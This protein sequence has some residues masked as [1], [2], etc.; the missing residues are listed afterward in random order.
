MHARPDSRQ[1]PCTSE[2]ASCVWRFV[3][4]L[5]AFAWMPWINN[6]HAVH[7]HYLRI[8]NGWEVWTSERVRGME[9]EIERLRSDRDCEKRIRKDAEHALAEAAELIEEIM[10]DKVNAADECEKWLRAYD[11]VRLSSPNDK[12]RHG[13]AENSP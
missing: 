11:P 9:Q 3:R 5:S 1:T 6:P 2:H 13:A 12:F 8:G 4:R 10:R 7:A